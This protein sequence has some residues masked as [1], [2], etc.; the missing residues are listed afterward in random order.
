M[1]RVQGG[2]R[3]KID[4]WLATLAAK[5]CHHMEPSKLDNYSRASHCHPLCQSGEM[6]KNRGLWLPSLPKGR[7]MDRH[8]LLCRH[9]AV[10]LEATDSS[11][12]SGPCQ[13]NYVHYETRSK[14][15]VQR[16]RF[17]LYCALSCTSPARSDRRRVG[18]SL[19]L[20][21]IWSQTIP[22]T[23]LR[24]VADKGTT[25]TP[26]GGMALNK[27]VHTFEDAWMQEEILVRAMNLHL[28]LSTVSSPF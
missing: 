19:G 8:R 16:K 13:R 12:P 11:N 2:A 7:T 9:C 28:F 17:E 1:I 18:A 20:R 26:K 24:Q 25:R 21:F 15:S 10:L 6:G 27:S 14:S 23:A 22:R 3:W 4:D 5:I